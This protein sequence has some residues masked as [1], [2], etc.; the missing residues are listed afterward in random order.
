MYK[1]FL[2]TDQKACHQQCYVKQQPKYINDGILRTMGHPKRRKP[3]GSGDSVRE[4]DFKRFSS[5]A[6]I[7]ERSCV[8]L[9]ELT[10]LN[11]NNKKHI[12]DKLIHIVSN[13]KVLILSY[14]NNK[15]K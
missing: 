6:N 14:E 13:I 12:N 9:N 11:K 8:S 10:N 1:E 15:N 3:Y 4:S 2:I 5:F 7:N